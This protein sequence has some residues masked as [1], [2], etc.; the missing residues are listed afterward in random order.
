M[1][2][3]SCVQNVSEQKGDKTVHSR[4]LIFILRKEPFKITTMQLLEKD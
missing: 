1:S 2:H 4:Y 3:D